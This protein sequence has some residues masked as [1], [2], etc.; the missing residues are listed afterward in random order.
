MQHVIKDETWNVT[1]QPYNN[2]AHETKNGEAFENLVDVFWNTSCRKPGFLV[3]R[4]A[5]LVQ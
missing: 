3:E 5:Y 1:D 2:E 4:K